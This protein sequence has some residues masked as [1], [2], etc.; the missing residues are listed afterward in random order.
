MDTY[1]LAY[2]SSPS[3]FTWTSWLSANVSTKTLAFTAKG[4]AWGCV[5][6]SPSLAFLLARGHAT[7]ATNTVHAVC[8]PRSPSGMTTFSTCGF[9]TLSTTAGTHPLSFS[10]PS[11]ASLPPSSV[12]SWTTF[13]TLLALRSLGPQIPKVSRLAASSACLSCAAKATSPLPSSACC[14]C[15]CCPFLSS[16]HLASPFLTCVTATFSLLFTTTVPNSNG[17]LPPS[18]CLVAS[19]LNT[20]C[21][22]TS[23]FLKCS[24]DSHAT[25]SSPSLVLLLLLSRGASKPLS[26]TRFSCL[27]FFSSGEI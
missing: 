13:L 6:S 4:S 17:G 26:V 23:F 5:P 10:L 24:R 8:C 9:P 2:L 1:R 7:P 15:C 12:F 25:G 27:R 3:T 20:T 21:C 16:L 18:R 19:T 22:P 11:S 14:C